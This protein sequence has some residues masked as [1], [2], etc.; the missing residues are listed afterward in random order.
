[1]KFLKTLLFVV[2][3]AGAICTGYADYQALLEYANSIKSQ[4]EMLKTAEDFADM[5]LWYLRQTR[6]K[7]FV[8]IESADNATDVGYFRLDFNR[9]GKLKKLELLGDY[10][11]TK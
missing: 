2:F 7:I 8:E 11:N 4:L 10:F 9:A 1:M 3:S 5:R 6:P